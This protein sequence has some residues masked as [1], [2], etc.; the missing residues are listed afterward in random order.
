YN[1]Y[2]TQK[3]ELGVNVRIVGI[4]TTDA[5]GYFDIACP[6][7]LHTPVQIEHRINETNANIIFSN[8]EL[9]ERVR[10]V[11]NDYEF[12]TIYQRASFGSNVLVEINSDHPLTDTLLIGRPS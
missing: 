10:K 5:Q 8:L 6:G 4:D 12:G 2:V 9:I 3:N 11:G 7:L 1:L